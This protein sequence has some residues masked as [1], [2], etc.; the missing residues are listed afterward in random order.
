MKRNKRKK[1]R[2]EKQE[3]GAAARNESIIELSGKGLEARH[4]FVSSI[5]S[6][7]IYIFSFLISVF[8][9]I[10]FYL[11]TLSTALLLLSA[12]L[13]AI[14]TRLLQRAFNRRFLFIFLCVFLSLINAI[15]GEI[16]SAINGVR[17]G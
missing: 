15:A 3:N 2:V 6:P 12:R 4:S 11:Y 7:F 5:F 17:G 16:V 13:H 10:G 8:Y 14:S 1:N 9:L